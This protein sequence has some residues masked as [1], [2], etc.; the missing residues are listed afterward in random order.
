MG[1]SE[2]LSGLVLGQQISGNLAQQLSIWSL[3]FGPPSQKSTLRSMI[4][5]QYRYV[6]QNFNLL[7][8]PLLGIT[9]E[10]VRLRIQ[11]R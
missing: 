2:V 3:I 9:I 11:L 7:L 1:P 8:G 10:S 5:Q 4:L 6:W